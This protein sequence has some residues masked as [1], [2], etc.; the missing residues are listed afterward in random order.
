M[1]MLAWAKIRTAK[2]LGSRALRADAYETIACSWLSLTTLVG[3]GLNAA[4]GWTWADPVAALVLVPLI[5]REGLEG[6]R[7][8]EC[9]GNEG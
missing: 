1:P 4:V 7:G 8:E 6:I 9:C 5:V 3:L 2:A